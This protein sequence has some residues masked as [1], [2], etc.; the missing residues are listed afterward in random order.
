MRFALLFGCLMGAGLPAADR[1]NFVIVFTDDHGFADLSA[2]NVL[3]DIRTPNIDA[4]ARR[5]VRM[6]PGYSTAPQ[7]RPFARRVAD[8]KV[9]KPIRCR[10]QQGTAGRIQR[11]ADDRGTPQR[12]GVCNRD[13]RQMALGSRLTESASTVLTMCS[14]RA[15]RG[16]TLT[17]MGTML[18]LERSTAICTTWMP[19]VRPLPRSSNGIT[20]KPFFLYLAYR[21]PHVPLDAT[22][23]YLDRFPGQMPEPQATG[24]G[25]VVGG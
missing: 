3:A 21:A 6:T 23:E 9:P 22:Q 5:G 13:D 18:L 15:G 8:G 19:A 24:L 20:T 10:K 2:Q 4:L 1:P 17:S 12:S 25:D 14:I 16:P 7:M 11:A